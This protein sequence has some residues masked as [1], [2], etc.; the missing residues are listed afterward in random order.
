MEVLREYGIGGYIHFNEYEIETM[1]YVIVWLA[2]CTLDEEMRVNLEA[3]AN[4][5]EKE[6]NTTGVLQ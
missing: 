3:A 1:Y 4:Y 5:L 2:R 6:I